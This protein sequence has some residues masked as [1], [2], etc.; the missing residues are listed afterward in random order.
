MRRRTSIVIVVG[1]TLGLMVLAACGAGPP[2]L[3]PR[4]TPTAGWPV[5]P[6]APST[7]MMPVTSGD[8][9]VGATAVLVLGTDRRESWANNADNTDTLM[10]FFLDPKADQAAILSIPRD[11]YVEIPGHDR[12]RINTA[13]SWGTEDG[14]GGLSLARKTVSDL[15]DVPIDH[16][17]L[18]DF[19]AF[20]A[21]VDAIG[22]IDVEV[23]YDI[24]DPTYPDGD[25][26]F[27]P[28]TISAGDHHLDGETAL[29]YARTRATYGGDF[30]R[31]TRQR[32]VVMAIRDRVVQKEMLPRLI[33]QSPRL[34]SELKGSFEADLSLKTMIDLALL[35]SRLSGDEITTVGIDQSC[36][37]AWTTPGGAEVL[38]PDQPA[39]DTLV[40]ETFLHSRAAN[41]SQ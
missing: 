19:N 27:D 20:T 4:P 25:T 21:V 40:R 18:V 29:K 35:A 30:D 28:F 38:L 34:W 12:G 15:L 24:N 1:M 3:P 10:V 39:I 13:Y 41:V 11:L 16:A 26:G 37:S 7:P 6:T 22:G 14:S 23:P 33:A 17:M 36:V 8:S 32:Q 9:Y 5:L 2:E 31:S